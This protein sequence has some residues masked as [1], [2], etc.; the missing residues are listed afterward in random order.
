MLR[1][2]RFLPLLI[3]PALLFTACQNT[4]KFFVDEIPVD[5]RVIKGIL[6]NG[7]PYIIRQNSK[8]EKR[9]ELR[10]AI[11]AGST[12]EDDNQQGFAHLVEH[13]AFNGTEDFAK[14]EII[15][16][17][18][19]IGMKFGAHLNAHTGF[20]ETVY[21]LHMPTDDMAVIE[22]GVHILENWAH[23]IS[24][25]P[26]EIDK[27]R[28]VVIEELRTRH[29]AQNRIFNK[30]LPILYPNTRYAKRLPI[31]KEDL[32]RNG[33]Y[34]DIKRYYVDWYRPEL[35][36]LVAVG[37]F[38]PKQIIALFEQYFG[39]I[40][41]SK[42]KRERTKFGIPDNQAPLISI[43]TDPELTNTA[44]RL[45]F[46]QPLFQIKN[47]A[48]LKQHFRHQ[49]FIGMLNA[50]ISE[51]VL[52][53]ESPAIGATA[54]FSSYFGDKSSLTLF[55][56]GKPG[57]SKQSIKFLLDKANQVKQ[58]G[59]TKAELS[60]QKA[61]LLS[62]AQGKAKK[63]EKQNS[64]NLARKYV[65]YYT[66]GSNI[67]GNEQYLEA[68]K[69]FLPKVTL[70]EVN[71][72]INKWYQA[73]NRL[74]SISAP[75]SEKATLPSEGDVLLLWQQA[76]QEKLTAYQEKSI[77][78]EL[79]KTKPEPGK[80]VN[81]HY[82]EA[83]DYHL[84]MLSNG[85]KVIVKNTDF[86]EDKI[87]F[88]ARSWGG[89]SLADDETLSVTKFTDYLM[90]MMG[91][92]E[93]NF[94]DLRKFKKG[95]SFNVSTRINKSGHHMS[96]NSSVKDLPFLMQNVY[97]KFQQPRKDE[98]AFNTFIARGVAHYNNQLNSPEGQFYEAIRLAQSGDD[99]RSLKLDGEL[100]KKQSLERSIDLYQQLFSNPADFHFV[101]VGNIDLAQMETLVEQYLA[102]L[103]SK[104]AQDKLI[105][106]PDQRTKGQLNVAVAKGIDPKATIVL[107]TLGH[108]AW[109]HHGSMQFS[110]LKSALST[111]LRERI[112]EDKSGAYGVRVNG[113]F[114]RTNDAYWT[115]ITFT[116]DPARSEELKNEV[117]NV[118]EEFKRGE[119]AEKYVTNYI[120]Q[121]VKS[122]QE[123]IRT[124]GFWKNYLLWQ[125]EPGYE[126]LPWDEA[127]VLLSSMTVEEVKVAANI[128]LNRDDS[129]E[130]VLMPE[131]K[132]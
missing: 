4:P 96:G 22:K 47:A 39:S 2:K 60:R 86:D 124:N 29:G 79:L 27:E 68:V 113:A 98:A 120:E 126:I 93:F 73:N 109:D 78:D 61:S 129:L 42:N 20:D 81:K 85:I 24:F 37:D 116:C 32:L 123:K 95:H 9:A 10:L 72:L 119:I 5:K 112:R 69:T 130:A 103:A 58:H 64:R 92:G 117:F 100:V 6:S 104:K 25:E 107:K 40:K 89:Y 1:K 17:I 35:M 48:D 105:N 21:K 52:K 30:E 28:G 44:V 106:L 49:L 111:A 71:Q 122:H 26:D 43:Q 16:Y 70:E 127:E 41:T 88:S 77:A 74:I 97:L 66:K 102:S 84:W 18:E 11:N 121:R 101:F 45:Q 55:A 67:L 118:I 57:K 128:F 13:M 8:P 51:D 7:I 132:P 90:N 59:F 62:S 87:I 3:I 125:H 12:L 23:K 50:R 53:V 131:L 54:R 46:K 15:E 108:Q 31:G 82:D 99:S 19:S 75:D 115:D 76:D 83:L 91:L 80:I 65:N 56:R 33:S 114:D 94:T 14:Q 63:V 36:S 34:E 110:V 38:E